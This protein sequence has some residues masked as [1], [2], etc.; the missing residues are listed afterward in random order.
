LIHLSQIFTLTPKIRNGDMVNEL[1]YLF[2]NVYPVKQ[3]R[4]TRIPLQKWF[5]AHKFEG[6]VVKVEKNSRGEKR[7]ELNRPPKVKRVLRIVGE[8]FRSSQ[9]FPAQTVPTPHHTHH[10]E[11]AETKTAQDLAATGWQQSFKEIERS[12][13][14][15]EVDRIIR[16][17]S[18]PVTCADVERLTKGRIPADE[19]AAT[20][21]FMLEG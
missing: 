9:T 13:A 14:Y 6:E 3:T 21:H 15:E 10:A 4:L 19:A 1:N 5:S 16:M 17:S 11:A 20:D 7:H 12:P 8:G 18:G 2:A